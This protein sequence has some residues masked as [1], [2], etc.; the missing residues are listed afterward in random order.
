MWKVFAILII[1]EYSLYVD[2]VNKKETQ[3]IVLREQTQMRSCS[4][5]SMIMA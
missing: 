3:N 5:Y 2:K 4:P 1:Y